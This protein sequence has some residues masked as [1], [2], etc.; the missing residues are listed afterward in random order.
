MIEVHRALGRGQ[1]LPPISDCGFQRGSII[2][3]H[4]SPQPYRGSWV[5]GHIYAT[6]SNNRLAHSGRGDLAMD[7]TTLK[8]LGQWP[9][10]PSASTRQHVVKLLQLF[11]E[12]TDPN[13]R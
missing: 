9:I 6:R 11:P 7:K 5:G 12:D 10:E 2:G 1:A 13:C 3:G 4:D 8:P